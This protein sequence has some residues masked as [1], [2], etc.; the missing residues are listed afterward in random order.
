MFAN[1]LKIVNFYESFHQSSADCSRSV[2]HHF[3]NHCSRTPASLVDPMFQSSTQF[4][5]LKH[6]NNFLVFPARKRKFLVGLNVH[7]MK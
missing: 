7:E 4:L 6:R 1:K 3:K 5:S 2:D